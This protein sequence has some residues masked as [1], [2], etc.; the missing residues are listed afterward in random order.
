MQLIGDIV[1]DLMAK[2]QAIEEKY[3]REALLSVM[4]SYAN[5]MNQCPDDPII[6]CQ[7]GTAYL[8]DG[9][10]GLA[11][12]MLRRS[13]WYQPDNPN[14]WSN[15]GCAYRSMHMIKEAK[16]CFIKSLMFGDKA[17]T[18]SNLTACFVNEGNPEQGLKYATKAMELA[19]DSPKPKWNYALLQLELQNWAEGFKHYD[20]GFFCRERVLR[21]YTNSDPDT[22][23][24]WDGSEGKTVVIWDEQGL[25][26]RILLANC[27]RRLEGKISPILEC[28][29]RLEGMYKRS[30]PW[31]EH[32]YPTAKDEKIDW[33]ANHKI[34]AKVALGSLPAMFWKDGEFDRTPYIKPDPVRV[35]S[36]R[37]RMEMAGPGPYIGFSWY[38][39]A[40]KTATEYRSLKLSQVMPLV[41]MGGTWIS[42]QY[43]E[44]ARDKIEKHRAD[45]GRDVHHWDDAVRAEDYDESI[46][47]AAACDLVIT[48]CTTM[49]HVCGAAGIPVWTLVPYK[50]AWRYP[51]AVHFPWYGDHAEMYHQ[52]K[53]D[54]WA[55]VLETVKT[56]LEMWL[57]DR[58]YRSRPELTALQARA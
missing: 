5:L 15:L 31:I 12:Q 11:S 25:G 49:V 43:H 39:G 9:R 37:A 56:E 48:V 27:L 19:P 57:E 17:E 29:P 32:I 24:W 42:L 33:V 16:D 51:G 55:S 38:G 13:L 47:L 46:A 36:Y 3:D 35:M 26:D 50:A 21:S 41:D 20:A 40:P 52:P 22:T 58:N 28:H 2:Q 18:F 14:I 1:N 44:W 6:L 45:T 8:Q 34:D 7:L 23:P 54:D 4:D 30:F 53:E 10:F